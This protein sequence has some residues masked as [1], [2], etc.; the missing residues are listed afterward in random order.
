MNLS[1]EGLGPVVVVPAGAVVVGAAGA[2]GAT[3]VVGAWPV[4]VGIVDG[5]GIEVDGF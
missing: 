3:V 2:V 5:F 4:V 1:P